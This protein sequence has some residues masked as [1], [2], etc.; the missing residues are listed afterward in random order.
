MGGREVVAANQKIWLGRMAIPLARSAI[1]Y[2]NARGRPE[3]PG[4]AHLRPRQRGLRREPVRTASMPR[5]RRRG[6]G[7]SHSLRGLFCLIAAHPM[8]AKGRGRPRRRP[9]AHSGARKPRAP[10]AKGGTRADFLLA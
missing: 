3:D 2:N 1:T 5:A 8:L 9:G 7:I 6:C 10:L 4:S